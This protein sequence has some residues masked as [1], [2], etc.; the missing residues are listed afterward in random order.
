MWLVKSQEKP[1]LPQS[2]GTVQRHWGC[3]G[4]YHYGHNG[5]HA[6]ALLSPQGRTTGAGGGSKRRG[7]NLGSVLNKQHGVDGLSGP[8][9]VN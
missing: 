5:G 9:E 6:R 2:A 7:K 3:C 8:G 1:E 4:L